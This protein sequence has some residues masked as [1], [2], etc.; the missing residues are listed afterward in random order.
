MIAKTIL[1]YFKYR[2]NFGID[3]ALEAI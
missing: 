2:N 3:I 1:D